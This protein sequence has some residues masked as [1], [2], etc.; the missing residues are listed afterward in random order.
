MDGHQLG[1]RPLAKSSSLRS[2]QGK[3][4]PLFSFHINLTPIAARYEQVTTSS[5]EKGDATG[6]FFQE[7]SEF[8]TKVHNLNKLVKA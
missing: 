8:W 2:R 6:L 5:I 3:F 7:P 1:N 4:Y